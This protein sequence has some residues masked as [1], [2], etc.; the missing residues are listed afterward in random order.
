M[1]SIHQI[2]MP[3]LA[4]RRWAEVNLDDESA[5]YAP[6][7]G[8]EANPLLD[9]H[10]QDALVQALAK[11]CGADFTYGGYLEWRGRLLRGCYMDPREMCHLG[12]DYNAPPGTP[13]HL[14]IDAELVEI[15]R[16]LDPAIGWGG[17]LLFHSP[18][19][20]LYFLFAHLSHDDLPPEGRVGSSFSSGDRV[21]SIG[22]PPTNGNVFP[23]LHVQCI[24]AAEYVKTGGDF[25]GYGA[26]SP[27]LATR[28]PPPW[29]GLAQA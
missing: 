18:E 22:A 6:A 8:D 24:A 12:V 19:R 25:D 2:L 13:V 14:P 4:D 29:I 26:I 7:K 1:Q 21:G 9:P 23:H 27:D 10:H 5:Y 20:N 15:K 16:D 28:Y 11:Q 17:R 3:S